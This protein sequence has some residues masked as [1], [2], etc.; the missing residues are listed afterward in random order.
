MTSDSLSYV[1][2]WKSN[3]YVF[4]VSAQLQIYLPEAKLQESE[5]QQ[6][7]P[8]GYSQQLRSFNSQDIL[9]SC[10]VAAILQT[11]SSILFWKLSKSL[12]QLALMPNEKIKHYYYCFNWRLQ[13][14]VAVNLSIEK[15]SLAAVWVFHWGFCTQCNLREGLDCIILLGG[16]RQKGLLC[17][18]ET[19]FMKQMMKEGCI[20]ELCVQEAGWWICQ[21]SCS[22]LRQ[23]L[24]GP[25]RELPSMVFQPHLLNNKVSSTLRRSLNCRPEATSPQNWY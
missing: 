1:P 19:L 6:N 18:C 11:P 22:K 24:D 20:C 25:Q 5:L 23:C 9:R 4:F 12:L 17:D 13:L 7:E 16:S 2:S 10:N 3:Q 8:P 21:Y 14:F 15:E